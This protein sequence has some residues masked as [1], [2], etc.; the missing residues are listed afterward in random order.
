MYSR[1]GLIGVHA[2][3]LFVFAAFLSYS[4]SCGSEPALNQCCWVVFAA[5]VFGVGVIFSFIQQFHCQD[6]GI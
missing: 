1:S 6:D 2:E 3:H 5:V 4:K